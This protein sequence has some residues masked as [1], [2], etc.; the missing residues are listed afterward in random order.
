[1]R[2]LA[3]PAVTGI[4]LC[5]AGALPC[6]ATCHGQSTGDM[7]AGF[8]E[9]RSSRASADINA[10]ARR[11]AGPPPS[12]CQRGYR[13]GSVSPRVC[14]ELSRNKPTAV[15]PMVR[16]LSSRRI[17]GPFSVV[18][19]LL[20]AGTSGRSMRGQADREF[21]TSPTSSGSASSTT[22]PSPRTL[23]GASSAA[24]RRVTAYRMDEHLTLAEY[25][26]RIWDVW[27]HGGVRPRDHM[28]HLRL[29]LSDYSTRPAYVESIEMTEIKQRA[30]LKDDAT[31]Q[32]WKRVSLGDVRIIDGFVFDPLQYSPFDHS[33]IAWWAS[34]LVVLGP[35]TFHGVPVWHVRG[36]G[37]GATFDWLIARRGFL[38]YGITVAEGAHVQKD[39]LVVSHIRSRFGETVAIQPPAA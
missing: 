13:G 23:L 19:A 24:Y 12:A 7:A 17:S 28:E 22:Y 34:H 9:M 25:G 32:R 5:V 8:L 15:R 14:G 3:I 30:W 36:T 1:M 26:R 16:H 31:R 33:G 39:G 6:A 38:P 37:V 27:M 11:A 2:S 18:G 20:V 4:M 21:G 10:L 29:H 35:E